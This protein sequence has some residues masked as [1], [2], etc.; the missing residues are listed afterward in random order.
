MQSPKKVD[1]SLNIS[2]I[3]G[4]FSVKDAK[5]ILFSMLEKRDKLSRFTKAYEN[6]RKS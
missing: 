3:V 5:E 2:L 6:R 1:T 4:K